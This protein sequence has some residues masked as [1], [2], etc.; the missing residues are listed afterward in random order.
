MYALVTD[1]VGSVLA[2]VDGVTG[3]VVQSLSYDAWGRVEEDTNP[4]FQPFGYAGGL[5]DRDTGL[6]HFGLREY[7]PEAGRWTSKD[8]VRFAG[9]DPNLYGY[10]LGDPVNGF[11]P[12][13]LAPGELFGSAEEAA[14]DFGREYYAQSVEE[15]REYGTYIYCITT[16]CYYDVPWP[17]GQHVHRDRPQDAVCHPDRVSH[18]HT[19]GD[20]SP[21]YNDEWPSRSDHWSCP[22]DRYQEC[23]LWTPSGRFI[24]Y[25]RSG[26]PVVVF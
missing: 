4:G 17:G 15:D 7:S 10:V 16:G 14:Y 3:A 19:H 25:S 26:P 8:P 12:W 9:G 5:Q 1:E 13:G 21:G 18:V 2:V 23:Y 24:R 6:V 20:E 22:D 11:D